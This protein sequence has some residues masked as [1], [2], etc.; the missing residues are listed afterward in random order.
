M[1]QGWQGLGVDE[2]VGERLVAM[3]FAPEADGVV[4][5]LFLGPGAVLLRTL[6]V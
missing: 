5:D 4:D 3:L 1:V 6:R 2:M